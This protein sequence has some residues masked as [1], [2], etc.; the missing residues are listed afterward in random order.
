MTGPTD[1]I[2]QDPAR[3]D[4]GDGMPPRHG[5]RW[6][7]DDYTELV[8]ACRDGCDIVEIARRVGRT[9]LSAQ[10]QLRRL[11][12]LDERHLSGEL[13]L[14]RLRQLD[15]D[16]DYD[17]LAALAQR[18]PS[19][20]DL[21][22][23]PLAESDARGVGGMTDDELLSISLAFA[24]CLFEPPLAL[25]QRCSRELRARRLDDVVRE[26]LSVAVRDVVE[27]RLARA[28]VSAYWDSDRNVVPEGPW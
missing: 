7:E 25:Q 19:P 16:G 21:S 13:A 17:W 22:L 3:S 8:R 23:A 5:T 10:W 4:D 20:W 28:S 27:E 2:R 14:A 15:A 12:P 24:S 11:L 18:T 9:W 1:T 26:R 6:T